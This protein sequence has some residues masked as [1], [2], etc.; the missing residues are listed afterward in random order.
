[1]RSLRLAHKISW[2]VCSAGWSSIVDVASA[3]CWTSSQ[4]AV[5][6]LPPFN[7][8]QQQDSTSCRLK[9]EYQRHAT[10]DTLDQKSAIVAGPLRLYV[11]S[12]ALQTTSIALGSQVCPPKPRWSVTC[13]VYSTLSTPQRGSKLQP[14]CC[15]QD[16]QQHAWAQIKTQKITDPVGPQCGYHGHYT[17]RSG[18]V[19]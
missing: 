17:A 13:Q 5:D 15:A 4:Y 18:L 16:N 3:R 1:M 19:L 11:Q 7:S 2:Y 12:Q 14:N 8:Y 6:Q 10:I 9:F